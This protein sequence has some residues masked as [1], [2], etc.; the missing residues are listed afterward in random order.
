MFSSTAAVSIKTNL[1]DYPVTMAMKDGRV[2]SSVVH[3]D[4]CGPKL[5][6]DAFKAMLRENAF[7]A[8]EL[9]IVTYL[10]AKA[11]GKPYVM[12][13]I[14]IS[15]RFQHK[16]IACNNEFGPLNP[17]DIE[18]RNVGVRTYA[19]TTGVW[20]RGILQHE[21][22]VDLNKVTWLT[23]E[24]AHLS[25]YRDPPN[26]RR[27][28]AGAKLKDML[29]K[30]EIAAAIM[31]ND[32]PDD[33]RLQ[34]LIPDAAAA[35]KEWYQREGVICMNHVFVVREELSQERPDVVRELF[36]MF[37]ES[38][39]L[40]PEQPGKVLPPIGV[41]ANRKALEMAIQYSYEQKVIPRRLSVDEL[42]DDTTSGLA[43]RQ[44]E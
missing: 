22:G 19:Q 40:A 10:Q 25:E 15:G 5:A 2:T 32:M 42:F 38:R 30:G 9:A 18:G 11:Y 1:A 13:P 26:V 23:I 12:L 41:E 6:H 31:G 29:F 24:D 21:Y 43:R 14:P 7:D 34:T 17:K 37:V 27:L 20:A 33:P 28:P 4:C 39:A 36:R 35:A 8:G 44:V 3:L 16:T